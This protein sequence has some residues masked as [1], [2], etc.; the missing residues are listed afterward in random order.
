MNSKLKGIIPKHTLKGIT[1]A[2]Y[3][4]DNVI[5]VTVDFCDGYKH[6]CHS[7]K[8]R[9]KLRKHRFLAGSQEDPVLLPVPISE[10]DLSKPTSYNITSENSSPPAVLAMYKAEQN[11]QVVQNQVQQFVDLRSHLTQNMEEASDCMNKI[12][13]DFH[14]LLIQKEEICQ[15]KRYLRPLSIQR[16]EDQDLLVKPV[17]DSLRDSAMALPSS[18]TSVAPMVAVLKSSSKPH[19]LPQEFYKEEVCT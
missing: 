1:I 19:N 7:K 2:L 13:E 17:S 4:E 10:F 16:A 5:K 12:L 3:I 6:K 9:D 8:G 15:R 18:S 11:Q 14:D